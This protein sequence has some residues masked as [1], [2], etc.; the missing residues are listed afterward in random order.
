[1]V[2]LV[3]DNAN[4]LS[5]EISTFLFSIALS[6]LSTNLVAAAI[7]HH[8]TWPVLHH[9]CQVPRPGARPLCRFRSL[10]Y[11]FGIFR[12]ISLFAW[13]PSNWTTS[14][15]SRR[16]SPILQE[17][18]SSCSRSPDRPTKRNHMMCSC[19]YSLVFLTLVRG[20]AAVVQ[21]DVNSYLSIHMIGDGHFLVYMFW[22]LVE[23]VNEAGTDRI[24]RTPASW[25]RFANLLVMLIGHP[26]T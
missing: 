21:A 2:S 14:I 25:P 4:S 23:S 10:F 5:L 7:Y 20:H 24:K 9:C 3:K 6:S 15:P 1:M 11:F 26:Y 12:T 19:F 22:F 13:R 17:H 18:S 8:E 16:S